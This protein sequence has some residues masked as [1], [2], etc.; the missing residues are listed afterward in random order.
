MKDYASVLPAFSVPSNGS[1]AWADPYYVF[2]TLFFYTS[3]T[4]VAWPLHSADPLIGS[5]DEP[6]ESP[7]WVEFNESLPDRVRWEDCVLRATLSASLYKLQTEVTTLD[8]L[9][10]TPILNEKFPSIGRKFD[11]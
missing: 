5:G 4:V 11:S 6:I 1:T 9:P 7:E 8:P 2:T 10:S 3:A